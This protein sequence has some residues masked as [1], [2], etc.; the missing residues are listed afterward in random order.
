MK[1]YRNIV[2]MTKQDITSQTFKEVGNSGM[3]LGSSVYL[4][5]SRYV[6]EIPMHCSSDRELCTAH[7]CKVTRWSWIMQLNYTAEL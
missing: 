2:K 4:D 6:S 5:S 3:H 7:C 1:V